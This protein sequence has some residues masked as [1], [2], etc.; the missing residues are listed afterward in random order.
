MP[1]TTEVPTTTMEPTTPTPTPS[2]CQAGGAG[3]SNTF[4][5]VNPNNVFL[6]PGPE[7]AEDC[8]TSCVNDPLCIQWVMGT[9]STIGCINYRNVG[10]TN[11]CNNAQVTI[12]ESGSIRC[13]GEGCALS[14]VGN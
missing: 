4:H 8:C 1:T 9:T 11:I 3:R 2:C 10:N 5:A 14:A 6:V 13:S 7:T 12:E